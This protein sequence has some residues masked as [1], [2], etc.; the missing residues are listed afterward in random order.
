MMKSEWIY[1]NRSQYNN[2]YYK[3]EN[4]MWSRRWVKETV[5]KLI[6]LNMGGNSKEF[7]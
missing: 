5:S 6:S 4:G 2:Y 3:T 1:Y 7:H